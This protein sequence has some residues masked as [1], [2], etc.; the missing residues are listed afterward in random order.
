MTLVE[1]NGFHKVRPLDEGGGSFLLSSGYQERQFLEI[2][3]NL[4]ENLK[5]TYRTHSTVLW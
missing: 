2:P 3:Q 5:K 1:K 4:P